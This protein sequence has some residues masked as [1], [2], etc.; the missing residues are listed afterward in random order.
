M[1]VQSGGSPN[2]GN[3]EALR[4]KDISMQPPWPVTENIIR[5]KVVAFAKSKS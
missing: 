5:G 1:G 4:K 2:F 3:F